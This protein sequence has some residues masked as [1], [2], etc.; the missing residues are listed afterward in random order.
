M[1]PDFLFWGTPGCRLKCP[2]YTLEQ[3]KH[4]DFSSDVSSSAVLVRREM[5]KTSLVI[6]VVVDG[7]PLSVL[8][9]DS[10]TQFGC[11]STRRGCRICVTMRLPVRLRVRRQCTGKQMQ[12]APFPLPPLRAFLNLWFAKPIVCMRVAF[13]ENDGNHKMTKT[14]KTTQTATKKELSVG[15]GEKLKGNL[16]K[17]S[18]DK[19]VCIDLP[20]PLLIPTPHPPPHP[21][22]TSSHIFH[23]KTYP[24]PPT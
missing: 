12:I 22:S 17:G 20:L 8:A 18:F 16:L 19:R 21:H 2:F 10:C 1:T 23:R 6:M 4:T 13:H 14:T 24:R 7:P 5:Q 11:P 15:F 9:S 3:R